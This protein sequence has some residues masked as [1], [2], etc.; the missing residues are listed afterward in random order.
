MVVRCANPWAKAFRRGETLALLLFIT[1][2]VSAL[3]SSH[4]HIVGVL[5]ILGVHHSQFV[6]AFGAVCVPCP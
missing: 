2:H 1:L 6:V 3:F 5:T 4:S